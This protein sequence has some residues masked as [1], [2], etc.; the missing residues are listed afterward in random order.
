MEEKKISG[1]DRLFEILSVIKKNGILNGL[2]PQNLRKTCE[3]LGPTFVK[4]GQILSNRPD[5]LSDDYIDEL[6]KLRSKVKPMDY[7]EV[8]EIIDGETPRRL[9]E[10]FSKIDTKPLGSASIAQVHR[11]TLKNGDEVVIKVQRRNIKEKMA[12]DIRIMKKACKILR[13]ESIINHIV[14]IDDTLDELFETCLEEMDFK[15][16]AENIEEFALHNDGYAYL[17][18]PKV[19]K[20]ITSEKMLVME[21]IDGIRINNID[22]LLK[23]GYDLEEISSKLADNYI[24]QALDTG[25][26]HADPHPDNVFIMDGKIVYLDFGMMGRLSNQNKGILKRCL[27]NINDNDMFELE[28]NLL[29]LVD[30]KGNIDH[31]KLRND[32]EHILDRNKSQ[33][34][35]NIDIASFANDLMNMFASNG[36]SV[37]HEITMLIRGIVVLEGTLETVNPNINLLQVIKNRMARRTIKDLINKDKIE[38]EV[39]ETVLGFS[40]LTKL[41]NDM[42]I[43]F[44]EASNGNMRLNMQLPEANKYFDRLEKM[45]HRIVVCILD[46][47]FILGAALIASNRVETTEQQFLFYLF[48]FLGIIFTIWLFVKMYLD[49]L[50]R[51]K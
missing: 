25:F 16:E 45:V 9:F 10:I 49:K 4:I 40:K 21:Y 18:V 36:L 43:F 23:E 32:L 30:A 39:T 41:P 17:K 50:S 38:K 6:S 7:A 8:L 2:T 5:L 26:F 19:Y 42:H 29:L 48:V 20:E 27:V 13:V 1:K 33:D 51:R 12:T 35:G 22:L 14:S 31:N 37:P 3:D 47:A 15:H 46:V 24:Y 34:I 44:K 11:A 28:K